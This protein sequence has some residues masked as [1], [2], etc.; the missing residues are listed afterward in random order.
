[1]RKPIVLIVAVAAVAAGTALAAPASAACPTDPTCQAT[2]LVA[3]PVVDA[4]VLAIAAAPVAVTGV[5][6]GT[7][8]TGSNGLP[9]IS[10]SMA[11]TTVTDTRLSSAGWSVTATAG[12]FTATLPAT[13]TIPGSA[14]SFTVPSAV[15][16][17]GSPA[18]TYSSSTPVTNGGT[19]ITAAPGSGASVIGPNTVAYT[20]TI[21]VAIPAG[22]G[23]STYTGTVTQS[24]S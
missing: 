14:A 8:T 9:V 24:V 6:L 16:A 20:P 2:T 5:P 7:A 23:L 15:A 17:L 4:G 18:L 1:M 11:L 10:G 22:T 12:T 21:N 13:G 19:L 3:V